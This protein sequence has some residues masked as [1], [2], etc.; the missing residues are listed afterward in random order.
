MTRETAHASHARPD[1]P[2]QH[3]DVKVPE[4]VDATEAADKALKMLKKWVRQNV[5]QH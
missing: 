2:K 4:T 1:S 5:E 3:V